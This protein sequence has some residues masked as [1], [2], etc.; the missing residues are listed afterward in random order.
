M[1]LQVV[2]KERAMTDIDN[3]DLYFPRAARE[4]RFPRLC[5][6]DRVQMNGE[7]STYENWMCVG[8]TKHLCSIRNCPPSSLEERGRT[9]APVEYPGSRANVARC[10]PK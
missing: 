10:A 5:T 8:R 6:L 3:K 7:A 4:E 9:S 2:V 1:E